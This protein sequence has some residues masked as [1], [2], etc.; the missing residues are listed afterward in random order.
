MSPAARTTALVYIALL[1]VLAG[2]GAMSQQR[3]RHHAGLLEAKEEA[4]VDLAA[5]RAEAAAVNGP[6]AITTWARTAGMVPAP[7][8]PLTAGVAP[9]L[10]APT[11][12]APISPTL[13][14]MTVW[15]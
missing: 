14:V 11:A 12:P 5:R 7:E 1:L 13:E 3:Y 15:R 10:P 2:L 6:L 9:G 4:L 8:A